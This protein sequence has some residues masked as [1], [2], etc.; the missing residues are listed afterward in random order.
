MLSMIIFFA[1]IAGI[2]AIAVYDSFNPLPPEPPRG[3]KRIYVPV[4]VRGE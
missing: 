1:A 3:G 4:W 2:F